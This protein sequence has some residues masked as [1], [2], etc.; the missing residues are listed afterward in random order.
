MPQMHFPIPVVV[1]Y[2]FSVSES[3]Q[4]IRD[5]IQNSMEASCTALNILPSQYFKRE[6]I[7]YIK[8]IHL[9]IYW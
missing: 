2:S 3:A 6:Y 7:K 1:R 8:K 9:K 4:M 5:I